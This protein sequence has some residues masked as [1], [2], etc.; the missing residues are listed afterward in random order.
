MCCENEAMTNLDLDILIIIISI[1]IQCTLRNVG[2]L[3]VGKSETASG[4][5]FAMP[6]PPYSDSLLFAHKLSA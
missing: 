3:Y 4:V 2:V 1:S 5:S 6:P